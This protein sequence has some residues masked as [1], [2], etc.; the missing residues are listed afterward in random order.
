MNMMGPSCY[1]HENNNP[2]LS[3]PARLRQSV[4]AAAAAAERLLVGSPRGPYSEFL[5]LTLPKLVH[6][7]RQVPPPRFGQPTQQR[8][9]QGL[10]AAHQKTNNMTMPRQPPPSYAQCQGKN[11]T[12]APRACLS[13]LSDLELTDV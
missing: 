7:P 4:V 6:S 13:D 2:A 3:S 9:G 5:S 11:N 12:S 10:G 8:S 1:I